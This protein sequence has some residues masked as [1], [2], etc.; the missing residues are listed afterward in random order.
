[1]VLYTAP[2]LLFRSYP[3]SAYRKSSQ[4]LGVLQLYGS[5]SISDPFCEGKMEG[6]KAH[7]R[8]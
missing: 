1:L 3:K 4:Y 2:Y 7:L 5:H 6:E 8:W